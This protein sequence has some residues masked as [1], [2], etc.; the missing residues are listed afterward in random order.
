MSTDLIKDLLAST[1]ALSRAL[2]AADAVQW[3][4]SPIPAPRED[5]SSRSSG[6]YSNPTAD[7]TLD[8]R[9]LAVRESVKRAEVVAATAARELTSTAQIVL[10]TVDR[11]QGD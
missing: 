5:T 11:W 6:G 8:A 10:D 1:L 2:D 4:K 9:R 7:T 3:E